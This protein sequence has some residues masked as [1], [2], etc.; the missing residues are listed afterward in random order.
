MLNNLQQILNSKDYKI[1]D[2]VFVFEKE[3]IRKYK[4]PEKIPSNNPF[5]YSLHFWLYKK[6]LKNYLKA[7]PD[8]LILDVG[9]G[10]GHSLDYLNQ[11]SDSLVGIDTDLISLLYAQKTTKANYVL[12]KAEKLPFKDNTFDKIISFNVLEHIKNDQGVIEE[13]RRVAKKG[14]EIL[15]WVPSLEGIRTNSKLKNLMHE[16]ESG[17]E[18]HFRDGYFMNNLKKLL[19]K[20]NIKIIKE[21]YT[22]F[23]FAELF[24]EIIKL[25]YS[26]KQKTYQRQTDIFNV[27]ESKLFTFY[28]I[29]IPLIAQIALLEDFLFS[30]SEKGHALIIKGKI[31]K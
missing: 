29:M 22:M 26:K 23:L 25:F 13:I 6:Y 20:N 7:K 30:H 15:I 27:T 14:A 24:T 9:C 4:I 18:K 28:K 21:R 10:V 11:F 3:K 8:D 1:I 16:E 2:G 5:K 17:Y 12:T 31:P 19:T